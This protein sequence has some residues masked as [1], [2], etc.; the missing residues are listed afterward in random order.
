[1]NPARPS[2]G[3]PELSWQTNTSP[4]LLPCFKPSSGAYC[5]SDSDTKRHEERGP[6]VDIQRMPSHVTPAWTDALAGN[7]GSWK[8]S[9]EAQTHTY[10]Q[11]HT[12]PHNSMSPVIAFHLS[13]TCLGQVIAFRCPVLNTQGGRGYTFWSAHSYFQLRPIQPI[14]RQ[15]TVW[16]RET[17]NAVRQEIEQIDWQAGKSLFYWGRSVRLSPHKASVKDMGDQAAVC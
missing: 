13:L 17:Q 15:V 14:K 3:E 7:W 16:P 12:H 8:D 4:L 1:M 5:S 6:G 10:A 11:I 2:P 9:W